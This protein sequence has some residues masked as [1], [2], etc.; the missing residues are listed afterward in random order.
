MYKLII[1]NKEKSYLD[2]SDIVK[3][4]NLSKSVDILFTFFINKK[5]KSKNFV[6]ELIVEKDFISYVEDV[7]DIVFNL[8]HQNSQNKRLS[9]K[10]WR[11]YIKFIKRLKV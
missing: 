4:L 8:F 1:S 3:E 11:L 6:I 10:I 5:I 9:K 2:L 7:E